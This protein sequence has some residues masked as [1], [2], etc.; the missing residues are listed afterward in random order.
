VR[1]AGS[2][3]SM[4]EGIMIGCGRPSWGGQAAML[5]WRLWLRAILVTLHS[6]WDR[7]QV[8]CK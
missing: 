6:K 5:L 3:T 4:T 8:L 1:A 2:P 7:H